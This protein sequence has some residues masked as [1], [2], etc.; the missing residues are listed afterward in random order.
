[1]PNNSGGCSKNPTR[2]VPSGQELSSSAGSTSACSASPGIPFASEV[3][4]VAGPAAG[5][6]RHTVLAKKLGVHPRTIRRQY[7][8]GGLPGA[9]EHGA[10]ILVV[11]ARLIRLAQAYGLRGIER[12]ATAGLL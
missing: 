3:E 8:R 12:M 5:D 1:M 11:P 7:L 6:V 2:R 10:R 4:R 9:K